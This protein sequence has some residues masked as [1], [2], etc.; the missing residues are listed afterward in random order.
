V[1]CLDANVVADLVGQRLDP[2]LRDD[3]EAHV[4]TCSD[5]RLLVG[6]LVRGDHARPVELAPGVQLGRYVI[7]R[8]LGAGGMGV[9]YAAFD[10]ELEREVA[11]KVLRADTVDPVAMHDRLL[12]EARTMA[13]ISHSGVVAIHDVGVAAGRVFVAMELVEGVTLREWMRTSRTTRA[14]CDVF[15]RAGRGLAAV[16]AAGLVHGD[17]KPDNVLVRSDGGIQVTDFGLARLVVP[18]GCDALVSSVGG[19]PAY[20]APE[21]AAGRCDA[22]SDQFSFC[23]SLYEALAGARAPAPLD[24]PRWLRRVIDRGLAHDPASRFASMEALVAELA[25]DRRRVVRRLAFAGVALMIAAASVAAVVLPQRHRL[26]ACASS[27]DRLAG[28]WD[29]TRSEAIHRAFLATGKRFAESEWHG[30]DRVLASRAASWTALATSACEADARGMPPDTARDACLVDSRD[31]LRVIVDRLATAAPTFVDHAAEAAELVRDARSCSVWQPPLPRDPVRRARILAAVGDFAV[32][33]AGPD[34]EESVPKI[35]A[36]LEALDYEP[37]YVMALTDAALVDANAGELDAM[38]ASLDKA[39]VVA[40]KAGDERGRALAMHGKFQA[41]AV[42]GD[43][44]TSGQW[45]ARAAAVL[46]RIGAD[47]DPLLAEALAED[48]CQQSAFEH[49]PAAT[50]TACEALVARVEHYEGPDSVA[51]ANAYALAG[52]TMLASAVAKPPEYIALVHRGIAIKKRELGANHSDLIM[53][54][55]V[56]SFA[57]CQGGQL[58]ACEAD[59]EDA[60]Q[61]AAE[62]E[63]GSEREATAQAS[64]ASA[65]TS[66]GHLDA[67]LAAARRAAEIENALATTLPAAK[68]TVLEQLADLELDTKHGADALAT[69]TR[70]ESIASEVLPA[71]SGMWA[72]VY[73]L[74]GRANRATHHL[75]AAATAFER[76]IKLDQTELVA[77]DRLALAFVLWDLGRD[78]SRAVG[79]ARQAAADANAAHELRD[80][81]TDWLA[82]HAPSRH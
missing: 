27:G 8:R 77:R 29:P 32:V 40:E 34:G 58:A 23:A 71:D 64:L 21:Q 41:A 54:L 17:F 75:P 53:N 36:E 65:Q 45:V 49:N 67:A 18:D 63:P 73:Y 13:K 35:L 66:A 14:I 24:A 5:C 22:R 50:K 31:E 16:H 26:A 70:L 48:R 38:H 76:A 60:V 39:L 28:V 1:A 59:A 7:V 44:T 12:R 81:A 37:M 52:I 15:A 80:Q 4:A 25:R 68:I 33:H 2:H 43:Y 55:A 46:E 20:M 3:A 61:I 11:L 74:A 79:L 30:V 51:A 62:T 57:E 9:V 56:L 10:P 82:K 6:E 47:R 19:T 78:R 42:V 69:V 72:A